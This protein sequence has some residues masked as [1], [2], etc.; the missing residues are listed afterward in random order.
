M[1]TR[2]APSERPRTPAISAV[3]IS[4]TKR[5]TTARRRSPGSRSTARQRGAAPRRGARR[6]PRGRAGR[7]VGDRCL[8]RS[9]RG[10]GGAGGGARRRRCGRSGRARPGTSRRPRRRPGGRAPRTAARFGEG[11]QERPLG[12]VLRLVVVAELVEGVAVHLGQVLPIQGV[13]LGRV[14]LGRLDERAVAIEVGE[15]RTA[16]L[17][18]VHLPECRS[19]HRVTPPP[20]AAVEADVADLADDDR[21]AGRRP[22]SGPRRPERARDRV[23]ADRPDRLAGAVGRSRSHDPAGRHLAVRPAG[24]RRSGPPRSASTR[25]LEPLEER[26]EQRVAVDRPA[27]RPPRAAR[28]SCRRGP[29]GTSAAAQSALMP[30]PTTT[31]G[32]ARPEAVG[33]AEDARPSLRSRSPSPSPR[34]R[35]RSATSGGPSPAGSPATASAASAIASDAIAA[36]RQTRSGASQSGRNPSDSSSA[37]PGGA[38]QRPT[39]AAA[40]GGLLVGDREADLRRPVGQPAADDVV[41]RAD[42]RRTARGGRGTASLARLRSAGRRAPASTGSGRSSSK[43]SCSARSAVSRSASAIMQVIRT[44]EVE[45]ISMLTPASASVPNIRAA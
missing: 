28:S 19:G 26:V 23:D 22:R 7:Q 4:S 20:A 21:A 5:R 32:S 16:L 36:S 30:I 11:G 27:A 14:R 37:A 9:S 6:R 44:S 13:E 42:A 40:T 2:T 34:R 31:R 3:D 35:G 1:R 18:P 17:R 33:L 15:A 41:R 25:G 38:T 24:A 39:V 29:A 45:I 43:A 10:G 8:E 12:G